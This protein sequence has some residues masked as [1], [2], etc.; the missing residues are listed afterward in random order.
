MVPFFKVFQ[1]LRALLSGSCL[2]HDL[3]AFDSLLLALRHPGKPVGL[4]LITRTWALV[5][6]MRL[7]RPPQ[8]WPLPDNPHASVAMAMAAALGTCGPLAPTLSIHMVR[9]H[10]SR[11]TPPHNPGSQL[12]LI[13]A[14][15]CWTGSVL[16]C[17]ASCHARHGA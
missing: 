5:V 17:H 7:T 4:K 1:Q 16:A 6:H 3:A 9:W 11:L 8:R 15:C 13:L 10:I 14:P 2:A 12:R